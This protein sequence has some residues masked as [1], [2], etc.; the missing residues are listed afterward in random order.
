[1]PNEHAIVVR[2]LSRKFGDFTA[3]DRISFTV[4]RG[5]VF[6][7]LGA[8]GAGKTTA[9]R[10]LNG[11]LLPTSGSAT[12]AGYDIAAEQENVRRNIGYM[13]QKFSLYEDMTVEENLSFYGGVYGMNTKAAREARERLYDRLSLGDIRNRLTASLPVGWKQRTSLACAIQHNPKI[14][15]LDEPT[16]GVDPVSRRAFWDI[17]YELSEQQVTIFVTTHYMDEAEYCGR[18]SIMHSG[19]ILALGSPAE[20]KREYNL[21]T[22]EDVFVHLAG[23]RS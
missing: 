14:I 13:S 22:I 17:I 3:V 7:F 2:E 21:P 12:V 8:N 1:M 20:L 11:I 6:G 15:F 18:I 23:G 9:I 19:K 16:G 4:D 10:M 5:E